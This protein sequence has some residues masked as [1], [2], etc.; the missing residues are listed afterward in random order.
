LNKRQ[1]RGA[2]RQ[3]AGR[4]LKHQR[5]L[6]E[7]A[8]EKA[9]E[10]EEKAAT[11]KAEIEEKAA[12]LEEKAAKHQKESEKLEVKRLKEEWNKYKVTFANAEFDEPKKEAA[13]DA[14]KAAK[15]LAAAH[16]KFA[17]LN[18]QRRWP[19]A[20]ATRRRPAS[21]LRKLKKPS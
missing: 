4:L 8:V 21:K 5:N 3:S 20:P 18:L 10:F 11:A 19:R 16:L 2:R 14:A 9:A 17:S 6:S 15:K 1:K 12:E 7:K 13:W